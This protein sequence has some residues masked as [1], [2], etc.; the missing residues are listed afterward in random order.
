MLNIIKNKIVA[1]VI[2]SLFIVMSQSAFTFDVSGESFPANFKM[3]SWTAGNGESTIT[4]EGIVGEG[5]GKVYLTHNFNVSA[6]DGMSGEFTGQARTI[7][8]DGELQMASLQ[9]S[10]SR[11]GKIVTMYSFDTLNNG[12]I[13]HAQGTV[14]LM[15][16][17]LKFKVFQVN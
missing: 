8:Q 4:S 13:N 1:G 3:T 9:G 6:D 10:W 11:E 15:E 16:G 5:Y 7:N 2:A 17:T 12:V 14:D